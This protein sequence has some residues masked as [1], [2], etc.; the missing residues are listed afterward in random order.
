[1][2]S[3]SQTPRRGQIERYI[4]INPAMSFEE[5]GRQFGVTG[6]AVQLTF[7]VAMA[8]LAAAGGNQE[9]LDLIPPSALEH[10]P[11]WARAVH[12]TIRSAFIRRLREE[13]GSTA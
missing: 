12:Q 6:Q 5:I 4:G 1:M 8:K 2:G 10:A 13:F 11:L 3:E 9:L 7:Y